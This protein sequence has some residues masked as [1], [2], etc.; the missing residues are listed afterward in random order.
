MTLKEARERLGLGAEATRQEIRDA[1]RRAARRWH[2]DRAPAGEEE[3]FR[4]RMQVINAAYQR[5]K[6]FVEHYRYHLE[7]TEEEADLSEW[8]Q[9]R[10]NVGVWGGPGRPP[11]ETG[12]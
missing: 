3:E 11:G 1:Y 12:D 5:L 10:F 8:W 2:P 7:E 4:R 9:E 6:T